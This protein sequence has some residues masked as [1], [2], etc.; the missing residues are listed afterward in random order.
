M[1]KLAVLSKSIQ[2]HLLMAY[3]NYFS[4]LATFCHIVVDSAATGDKDLILWSNG[5]D[6]VILNIHEDAV[7]NFSIDNDTFSFECRRAGVPH[8]FT[9]QFEHVYAV[10]HP[11]TEMLYPLAEQLT[12]DTNNAYQ[13]VREQTMRGP[14]AVDEFDEVLGTDTEPKRPTGR[15]SLKVVK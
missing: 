15:P 12:I 4:M 9:I 10:I 1:S 6:H 11:L 8:Y 2:P 14:V 7:R 13:I 3:R 5:K